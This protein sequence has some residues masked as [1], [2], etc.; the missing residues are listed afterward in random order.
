MAGIWQHEEKQRKTTL[1][2][3]ISE[4]PGSPKRKG[5]AEGGFGI[6]NEKQKRIS[7]S[8]SGHIS[9]L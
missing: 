6:C 5:L 9:D 8:S 7:P 4:G 2:T 3:L 1:I